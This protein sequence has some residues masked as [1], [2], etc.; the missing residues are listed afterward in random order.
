MINWKCRTSESM[1]RDGWEI[2]LVGKGG[3]HVRYLS[4]F[5]ETVREPYDMSP[6]NPPVLPREM[7]QAVMDGLW[8]AGMR[9]TGINDVRESTAALKDHLK[10]MR[11]IAAKKIGV[12][13]P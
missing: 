9:P 3:S 12:A 5:T 6:I 7:L 11:A 4:G 10:D 2:L 13:L 8:E 1:E